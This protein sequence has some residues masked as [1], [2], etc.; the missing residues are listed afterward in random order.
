ML[1]IPVRSAR[2]AKSIYETLGLKDL[3]FPVDPVVNPYSHDARLNGAIFAD[4]PVKDQI[5][6]FERLLIRP[7]DFPNRAKLAYLWSKGDQESGRG[8]G[9]TALLRYFRQR[10]NK[11]WGYSEFDGQFSAAVVY[12]S[13]PSQVDRRYMEQLALS[14]LVD[15]CKGDLLPSARATLRLQSLPEEKAADVVTGPDGIDEPGRVLSDDLLRS[16][17][18]DPG[19][20]DRTVAQ[21]LQDEGLEPEV[22]AAFAEGRFG[23]YLRSFRRDSNLEP[24]YVPRDTRILDYSRLSFSTRWLIIFMLLASGADICSLMI[25]LLS[26]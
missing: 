21:S 5:D 17:G 1:H 4:G 11:D 22:A 15:I 10:I 7:D 2:P 9:K 12:V 16:K 3:P 18:I 20:T 23:E 19:A 26:G 25:S 6:K 13:F 8:M 24:L 14:A